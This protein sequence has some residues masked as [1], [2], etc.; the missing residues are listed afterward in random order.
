MRCE[1]QHRIGV[2]AC[3][4]LTSPQQSVRSTQFIA[5]R[6]CP[7]RVRVLTQLMFEAALRVLSSFLHGAPVI[8]IKILPKC[9]INGIGSIENKGR[10]GA[11]MTTSKFQ[12]RSI[13]VDKE[14][15]TRCQALADDWAVSVS[16]LIRL[17]IRDAYEKHREKLSKQDSSR[18]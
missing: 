4:D 13:N 2:V 14:T 5:R 6:F 1:V 15:I 10:L 17:L 7:T 12:R 8:G 3:I 9:E 16:V 18:S 11:G